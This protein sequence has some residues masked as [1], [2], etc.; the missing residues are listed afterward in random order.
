MSVPAII[1][2]PSGQPVC[3]RFHGDG[4]D[5]MPALVLERPATEVAYPVLDAYGTVRVGHRL[6][7]AAGMQSEFGSVTPGSNHTHGQHLLN[8]T[9]P[10][11]RRSWQ[12]STVD[13]AGATWIIGTF[14]PAGSLDPTHQ[15]FVDAQTFLRVVKRAA[16]VESVSVGLGVPVRPGAARFGAADCF[17]EADEYGVRVVVAGVIVAKWFRPAATD[18]SRVE[19]RAVFNSELPAVVV[20]RHESVQAEESL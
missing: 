8:P 9:C 5:G 15:F 3:I 2:F 13:T 1:D 12:F 11:H 10:G 7:L 19:T 18:L 17:V 4:L 14:E 6:T 16:G 20:G